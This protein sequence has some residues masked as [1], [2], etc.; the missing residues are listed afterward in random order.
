MHPPSFVCRE[1]NKIHPTL[2]LAWMG[3]EVDPKGEEEKEEFEN[4]THDFEIGGTLNT[5]TFCL[6]KIAPARFASYIADRPVTSLSRMMQVP[7]PRGIAQVFGKDGGARDYDPC[8]QIP[9]MVIELPKHTVL[10]GKAVHLVKKW[11]NNSFEDRVVKPRR[12]LYLDTKREFT[13]A[14]RNM[15]YDLNRMKQRPGGTDGDPVIPKK[16]RKV[17]DKK[18]EEK[19]TNIDDRLRETTLYPGDKAI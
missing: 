14:Y 9:L 11:V 6:L 12:Q 1:L 5:G 3:R 13:D 8:T 4:D 19:M 15:A 10:T 7:L 16:F 18:I 17:D 2:R